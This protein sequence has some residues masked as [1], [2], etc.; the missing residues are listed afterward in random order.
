MTAMDETAAG[1][2]AAGDPAGI[3]SANPGG[4][5]GHGLQAVLWD[6]D[7]TL[8]DS[9]KLW[10]VSLAELARYLGGELS[11]ATR[12]AMV[13]SSMWRTLDMMF[14]EVG[15]EHRPDAMADAA[16][17]LSRR[18]Q[19]L[20]RAGLPWRPG[21]LEALRTARA[22]GLGTALVTSTERALVEQALD[23]IGREFF[24][25]TVCGDEV[26]A[27]KPAPDP[28][29]IAAAALGHHP[30]ECLAVEDSPTGAAAAT[31]AGCPVL[32]VPSEV[33]VPAAP[34]RVH[35]DSLVGLTE[36]ELRVLWARAVAG[37]SPTLTRSDEPLVSAHRPFDTASG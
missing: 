24:D 30:A 11:A 23:S 10:D 35:R 16:H 17:W 3:P 19:E 5:D 25:V 14:D 28:Y 31:A 18:T 29:L 26:P 12:A 2:E 34:G 15:L 6:M 37:R 1:E 27:T 21:A 4:S 8:V 13:G 9:E 20:F 33:P 22:S 36:A 32:V 7:G